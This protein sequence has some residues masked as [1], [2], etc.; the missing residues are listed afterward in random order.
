[1]SEWWS[2]RN[3]LERVA[4]CF[5]GAFVV[6]MVIAAIAGGGDQ[7]DSFGT[8]APAENPKSADQKA[9]AYAYALAGER[10]GCGSGNSN[11]C[12]YA[13]AFAACLDALTGKPF[14]TRDYRT[15]FPEPQYFD[16]AKTAYSDCSQPDGWKS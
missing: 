9:D 14:D 15:Q 3:T 8:R 1:M 16:A 2:K 4:L 10:L 7:G 13:A 12:L 5:G 11:G 6:L